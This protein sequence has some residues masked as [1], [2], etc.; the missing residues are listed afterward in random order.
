MIRSLT[1][2]TKGTMNNATTAKSAGYWRVYPG[3]NYCKIVDGGRCV[4]DGAGNYGSRESCSVIALRQFY[5]YT[6]QYEVERGY[7][8]L[9]VNGVQYKYSAPNGVKMTQ[10]A[11]LEWRSDGSYF[12]KGWKV[13]AEDKMRSTTTTP[14]PYWS[15][16]SGSNYCQIVDGGRCVT[17]GAGN[18][19]ARERCT[20]IARRQFYVYTMQYDVEGCCDYLQIGSTKFK[21]RGPH[22]LKVDPGTSIYWRSDGAVSDK[23]WKICAS[24]TPMN[25][26]HPPTRP[27]QSTTAT[28]KFKGTTKH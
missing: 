14:K 25:V 5:V 1:S 12:N 6:M 22:G 10:G 21:T 28:T 19:G 8:Y 4:T 24:E 15:L 26:T 9:T 23:G 13:C 2:P 27:L 17:D 18:Y 11:A 7:D 3:P 20:V 16:Y